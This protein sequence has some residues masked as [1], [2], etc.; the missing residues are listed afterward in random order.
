MSGDKIKLLI[1]AYI[2]RDLWTNSEFYEIV[3]EKEIR[4]QR[5]INILDNWDHYEALLMKKL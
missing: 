4:Y 1:K 2:A 5:A 3:N